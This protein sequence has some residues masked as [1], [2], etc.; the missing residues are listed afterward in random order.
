ML[1]KLFFLQFRILKRNGMNSDH[2]FPSST[3]KISVL[4]PVYNDIDRV[5]LCIEK[6]QAIDYPA[7]CYEVIIIDNGST[8]GTYEYL[9]WLMECIALSLIHI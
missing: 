1:G 7:S 4:V 3:P 9:Q 2:S 5:G 6:L 8:D